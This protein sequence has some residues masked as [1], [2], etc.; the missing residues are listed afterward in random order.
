VRNCLHLGGLFQ[1][2]QQVPLIRQQLHSSSANQLP[3][4]LEKKKKKERRKNKKNKRPERVR[5]RKDQFSSRG[6]KEGWGESKKADY[7]QSIENK[8]AGDKSD[9]PILLQFES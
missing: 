4:Y 8:S 1:A 7:P 3:P 5:V 6:K 2:E 9:S